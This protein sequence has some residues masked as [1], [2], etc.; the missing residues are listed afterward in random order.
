MN[1][2]MYQMNLTFMNNIVLKAYDSEIKENT[3]ILKFLKSDV[4]IEKLQEIFSI[5][6]NYKTIYKTTTAGKLVCKFENYIKLISIVEAIEN[7]PVKIE[8]EIPTNVEV[9]TE[10]GSITTS[11]Q[12]SIYEDIN[13]STNM[14]IATLNY[15]SPIEQKLNKVSEKIFPTIDINTCTL[16][17][18]KDYKQMQNKLALSDFLALHPLLWTDGEYYGV[19][20]EDQ[21]EMALDLSAYQI[22]KVINPEWKLEWHNIKK[23]CREFTL[24][25]YNALMSAIIDFVYPYRKLQENYKETIYNATTKESVLSIDLVYE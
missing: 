23:A 3:L 18:L 5:Q 6:D 2:I 21:M 12:I 20:Q 1:N 15:V 9:T 8:K 7:I 19:K 13:I 25:E 4:T 17:E 11:S 14:I 24:Q 22:K 10:E 16:D